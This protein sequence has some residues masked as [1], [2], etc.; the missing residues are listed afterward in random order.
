MK[1][2]WCIANW[3][4]NKTPKEAGDF[5]DLL[6]QNYQSFLSSS[7]CQLAFCPQNFSCDIV[8][9]KTK[10]TSLMWGA[11]NCYI[12]SSGAY[13]GEN[14]PTLLKSMGATT[15]LVGHS[16]RRTLFGET[17]DLISQKMLTAWQTGLI[18]ILCVGENKKERQ[19]GKT[20]EII[21]DQIKKA[22]KQ[23]DTSS[24]FIIA[25]EPL[26]AIATGQIPS[27]EMLEE[28][29][30][31]IKQILSS[32]NYSKEDIPLLYGGSVTPE[33]AKTLTTSED[34]DGFLVGGASLKLESFLT[35]AKTLCES[36]TK[37]K[38]N[39]IDP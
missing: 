14:S 7:C 12:K 17:N 24:F 25:Y 28:V 6:L 27:L 36:K 35:I 32:L 19:I 20:K 4:L 1:K 39:N 26:W 8:A 23:L 5:I 31:W 13:T 3:K 33:N 11:Q 22:L 15:V 21:T 30:L 34:I 18:P 16:E 37:K 10:N 2:Y 9:K 38:T 29:Y